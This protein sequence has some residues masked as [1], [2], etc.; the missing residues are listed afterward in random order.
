MICIV[1][2]KQINGP[3]ARLPGDQCAQ[4]YV[5]Y[6]CLTITTDSAGVRTYT[7]IHCGV[8]APDVIFG[9][10]AFIF[11]EVE[12]EVD[13]GGAVG[14]PAAGAEG[15]T[16]DEE[17]PS[18]W[19]ENPDDVEEAA[20]QKTLPPDGIPYQLWCDVCAIPFPNRMAKTR[21]NA[22]EHRVSVP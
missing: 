3:A 1:C 18:N 21:H 10:I 2:E 5:H 20:G 13:G 14:G 15:P 19:E 17:T 16:N 4:H 6:D 7:C 11:I 8:E 9:E 22:K 12:S